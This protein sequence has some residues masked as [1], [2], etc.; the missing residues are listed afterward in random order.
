MSVWPTVIGTGA[1]R[2]E[3]AGLYLLR[4]EFD[5]MVELHRRDNSILHITDDFKQWMFDI[6][7]GHIGAVKSILNMWEVC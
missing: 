4:S 3:I 2:T 1:S 5:E 7:N 6:T